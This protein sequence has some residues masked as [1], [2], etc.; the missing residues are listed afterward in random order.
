MDARTQTLADGPT[1]VEQV[2]KSTCRMCHG[3]CSTLVHVKDRR[4]VKI[5]GDPEGPLNHGRLCPMG[6]AS[7]ELVHHPN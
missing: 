6:Q 7:M 5:E 3:G 2:F 1:G 4:I